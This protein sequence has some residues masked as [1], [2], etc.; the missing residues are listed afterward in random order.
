MCNSG[1]ALLPQHEGRIYIRSAWPDLSRAIRYCDDECQRRHETESN[2]FSASTYFRRGNFL[3]ALFVS[4]PLPQ[5]WDL[6]CGPIRMD[7]VP[8]SCDQF[9]GLDILCRDLCVRNVQ[10]GRNAGATGTTATNPV[11]SCVR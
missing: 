4:R 7:L 5:V 10:V 8:I 6:S 2:P 3:F 11:E 1:T 9:C